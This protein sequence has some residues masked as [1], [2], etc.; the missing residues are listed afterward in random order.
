MKIIDGKPEYR[1]AMVRFN[2]QVIFTI[3]YGY[4]LFCGVHITTSVI[5]GVF[6]VRVFVFSGLKLFRFQPE[7]VYFFVEQKNCSMNIER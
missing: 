7:V 1:G 4:F 5:F 6:M 2:L 3:L